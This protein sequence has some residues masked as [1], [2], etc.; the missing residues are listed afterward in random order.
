M[1]SGIVKWLKATQGYGFIKHEIT[2]G[3]SL[4]TLRKFRR[5]AIALSLM[6]LRLDSISS[7]ETAGRPRKICG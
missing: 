7:R 3:T 1:P 5:L 4:F 6:A 2:D